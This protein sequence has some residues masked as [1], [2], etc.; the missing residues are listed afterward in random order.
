MTS[1]PQP[2]LDDEVIA[3]LKQV[4]TATLATQLFRRGFRQQFLVGVSA[5][6][7]VT[8]RVVGEAFTMRF[9]PS[10]EDID[11]LDSLPG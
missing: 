2:A 3:T 7:S 1:S 11:T 8:E 4:S 10:R 5:L 6:G 9:I